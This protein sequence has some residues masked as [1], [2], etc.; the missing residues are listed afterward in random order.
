[1]AAVKPKQVRDAQDRWSWVERSVWTDSM[2]TTLEKGVKGEK[3]YSLIDKVYNQSNLTSSWEKVRKNKG[4]SGVD[5]QTIQ[6]FAKDAADRLVRI[7]EELRDNT[8]SPNFIRREYIP[9]AGSKEKRP[10]GIPTVKDRV[11]QTAIRNVIEPIYEQKFVR[12]SY[13]FRPQRSAKDALRE[14]DKMLKEGYQYVVDADIEKYFD[15]INH[16]QLMAEVSKEITDGRVLELIGSYL[17]QGILDT[18]KEWRAET[19][20]PQGAVISP[21]LANIYLHPVDEAMQKAGYQMIRYADDV[22][23]LC[24]RREEAE[25]ALEMLSKLLTELQLKL[26]SKK[27]K[28]VDATERGGFDFLGYHFERGYRWPSKKSTAKLRDAIRKKTKRN[29]G[30]SLKTI[31]ANINPILRGWFNYFKH[32]HRTTF[33]TI[34][35]WVRMRLR[36]ILRKRHGGRGRGRGLDHLRWTNKYFQE[37]GLFTMKESHYILCHSSL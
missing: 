34:D 37:L 32:S 2:L 23:I 16:Q 17:Q 20:T 15:T 11:V 27:T 5:K 13:G 33:P 26:H 35:G 10:L 28:I 8:Y 25:A 31:L 36:S 30:H 9:K 4:S 22:V 19:G 3:W 18:D 6:Q 7:A 21:L 12:H 29:N 24:R 14:V 1:V